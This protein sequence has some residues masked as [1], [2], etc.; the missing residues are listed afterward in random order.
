MPDTTHH[1]PPATP[2]EAE[3][4]AKRAVADH[5]N[6]C[7][8]TDGAQVGNYLMKLASVAGVLM[9]NAEGSVEA[10]LRLEGTA[11]FIL[12]TMPKK[13]ANLRPVQ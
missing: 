7:R 10:A 8:M 9:A 13:P 6:A 2:D 11:H 4:M 12:K 3:E 5:L 1:M